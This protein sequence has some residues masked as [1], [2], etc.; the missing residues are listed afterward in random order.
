MI[1][2]KSKSLANYFRK[3]AQYHN[4]RSLYIML[5][6]QNKDLFI[7]FL[8][9]IYADGLLT[10]F[11]RKAFSSIFDNSRYFITDPLFSSCLGYI[12]LGAVTVKSWWCSYKTWKYFINS[13][14]GSRI[15]FL[16]LTREQDLS[17]LFMYCTHCVTLLSRKVQRV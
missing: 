16:S 13:V 1:V 15:Y 14:S 7:W 3:Q 12:F 10:L 6:L 17:A 11:V 9:S 4:I 8:P 2:D 5:L